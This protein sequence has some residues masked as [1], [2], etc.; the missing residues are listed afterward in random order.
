MAVF[1][2]VFFKLL[3]KQHFEKQLFALF[4]QVLWFLKDVLGIFRRKGI[5]HVS[6]IGTIQ[7]ISDKESWVEKMEEIALV[8][9]ESKYN[10]NNTS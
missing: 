3:V 4:L 9:E 6:I 8:L 2:W 5:Y 10:N 7:I 1:Y